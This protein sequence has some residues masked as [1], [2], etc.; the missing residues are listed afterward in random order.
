M[1]EP[2]KVESRHFL[3]CIK[4]GTTP[5]SSGRDGLQVVQVLEAS[6]KS[7][8]QGGAEVNISY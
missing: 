1:V 3:D 5:L 2:L 7:L 4:K 8:K 6:T